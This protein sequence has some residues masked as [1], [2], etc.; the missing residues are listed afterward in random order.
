M[1]QRAQAVWV[2]AAA[3]RL[4]QLELVLQ[5]ERVVEEHAWPPSSFCG[6]SAWLPAVLRRL[7][8]RVQALVLPPVRAPV[9]VQAQ[10]LP[11]E[12]AVFR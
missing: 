3:L 6:L 1:E 12:R 5:Q 10:A 4:A 2:L 7:Q 11:L 8:E 9:R